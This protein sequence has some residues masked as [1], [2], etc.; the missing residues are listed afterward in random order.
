[1]RAH[2]H[3]LGE[4]KFLEYPQFLSADVHAQHHVLRVAIWSLVVTTMVVGA[5][6]W[7]LG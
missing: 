1:M 6:A 7:F 2:Q 5:A 4:R 3:H